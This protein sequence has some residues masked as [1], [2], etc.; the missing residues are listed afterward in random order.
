MK[1][2]LMIAV[3]LVANVT[4]ANG[5]DDCDPHPVFVKRCELPI[6]GRDG[7]DGQDGAQGERGP[8]GPQGE[9]GEKGEKGDPGPAGR[10]GVDGKDGVVP[11]DWYDRLRA[12]DRYMAAFNAIQPQLPVNG[13]HRVTFGL[14]GSHRAVGV[15]ASWSY[16]ADDN[17]SFTLGVGMA[18]DDTV[19]VMNFGLEW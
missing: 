19:A 17:T 2:V 9:R 3:L 13:E 11:T 4:F 8:V 1:Y 15:A 5:K 10:D 18:G 16:L 7:Q 12:T 14:A 6:E